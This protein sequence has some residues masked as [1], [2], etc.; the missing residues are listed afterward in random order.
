MNAR[1]FMS[2]MADFLPYAVSAADRPVRS[3]FRHHQ[4]A[5]GRPANPW[6][7]PELF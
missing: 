6:G 7:R 2:S 1:R 5:I 4:P 3:V